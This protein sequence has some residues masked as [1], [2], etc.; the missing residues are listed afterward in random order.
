MAEDHGSARAAEIV[1]AAAGLF[2]QNGFDGVS[3]RDICSTLG[4]NSSIVSYYFGGKKGLYLA[5]MR[6]LFQTLSS[7]QVSGAESGRS[8]RE[9]LAALFQARFE[10]ARQTPWLSGLLRRESGRP[11]PEFQQARRESGAGASDRLAEIIRAGQREGLFKSGPAE[12]LAELMEAMLN[13]AGPEAG[14]DYL[15]AL[16]TLVF[17]GLAAARPEANDI[18]PAIGKQSAIRR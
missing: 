8:P 3:V 15:A 6:R 10:A 17:E 18:R 4:V 16:Q 14:P 2:A 11:S 12:L 13:A 7:H 5:V 1:E 9:E